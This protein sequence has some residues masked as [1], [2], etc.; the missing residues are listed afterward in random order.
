MRQCVNEILSR[1]VCRAGLIELWGLC[2]LYG[3]KDVL[4]SG[5]KPH[6]VVACNQHIKPK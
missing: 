2:V 6:L 3:T 1:S 4:S 5:W